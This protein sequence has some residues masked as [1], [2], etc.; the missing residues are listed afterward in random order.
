MPTTLIHVTPGCGHWLC[1]WFGHKWLQDGWWKQAED[2][3]GVLD[4]LWL[5]H[6]ICKRCGAAKVE[7]VQEPA[8]P[9]DVY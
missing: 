6:N 8:K 7:S 4:T 5:R 1:R 9:L 3:L 2:A